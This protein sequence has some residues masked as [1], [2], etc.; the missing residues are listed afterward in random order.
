MFFRLFEHHYGERDKHS[1]DETSI[2]G[3][4]YVSRWHVK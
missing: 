1:H 3:F 4:V 2:F